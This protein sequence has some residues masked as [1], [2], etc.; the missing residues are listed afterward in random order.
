MTGEI[1]IVSQYSPHDLT[2]DQIFE[3]FLVLYLKPTAQRA[4]LSRLEGR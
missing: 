3:R 1:G 2:D 4:P